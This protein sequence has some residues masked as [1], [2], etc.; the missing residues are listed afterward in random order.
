MRVLHVLHTSLPFICGYSIRSDYILR[1]QREQGFEPFVV[2]SGQQ[3]ERPAA[4]EEL[5]G[6]TYYRTPPTPEGGPRVP[7]RREA[8]LMRRLGARV[9][10]AIAEVRPHLVHAHSPMLV[11]LPALWAARRA[12][13]P[14]VYEIRDL[15]ENA[16]VDRGKFST[17]SPL[18]R[19]ARAAEGLLLTR[20]NAVVTICESLRAELAPRVAQ[21]GALSV[22]A[23]GV[24]TERFA[25][26]PKSAEAARK[27]GLEGKRVVGYVGTFQPY[28]GLEVLVRSMKEIA[29]A[30]PDA[31]LVITGAGGEEP[32]LRQVAAEQKLGEHVVFT[33][34][35]PHDQVFD[36][37]ALADVLVYP[38]LLTRTTML[39]TPLKPLEAMAMARAVMVSDVPAMRELV[40]DGI[41]GA[42]FR[43]GDGA[44]LAARAID[45]LRDEGRRRALGAAARDYVVA[46]RRWPVLVEQY[47]RVYEAALG[48]P[49]DLAPARAAAD[50]AARAAARAQ[51]AGGRPS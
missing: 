44:D 12:G 48:A 9:A 11:G 8:D 4:R 43:A 41:T 10:E 3:P 26:R 35:L 34:R 2:T 32:R 22:V 33:G 23:N 39:T 29:A 30:L 40:K 16:S 49:L 47:Q 42:V 1:N 21:S 19:A 51:A 20:A 15:W 24:D 37:Y 25:P 5:D 46:H 28:E 7:F 27:W 45:L 13:L 6:L 14:L 50:G 17:S 38:R 18:Y 31:R 36:V